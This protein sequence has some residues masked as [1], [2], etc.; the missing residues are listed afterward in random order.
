MA[1]SA[2]MITCEAE[3][4]NAVTMTFSSNVPGN[5]NVQVC[6]GQSTSPTIAGS[7]GT[8]HSPCQ[9]LLL[10]GKVHVIT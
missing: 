4:S 1:I 7:T 2:E 10:S 8:Y 5:D 3:C 9:W 6:G